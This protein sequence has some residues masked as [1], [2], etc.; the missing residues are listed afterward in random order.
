MSNFSANYNAL[1]N[2]HKRKEK[3]PV[4][5]LLCY[6]TTLLLWHLHYFSAGQFQNRINDIFLRLQSAT[7]L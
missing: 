2:T 4:N 6:I 3:P 1:Y 5:Q 7:L